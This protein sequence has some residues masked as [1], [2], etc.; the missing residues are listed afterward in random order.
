M[1]SHIDV[2]A[3]VLARIR[4][5]AAACYPHEAIGLLGAAHGQVCAAVP[6]ANAAAMPQRG[7]RVRGDAMTAA[8]AELAARELDWIGVYHSHPDGSA[9]LSRNDVHRVTRSSVEMV[10]SVGRAG[11]GALR[12]FYVTPVEQPR[13]LIVNA[14]GGGPWTSR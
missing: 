5:H 4:D 2:A 13:E 14:G 8:L 7:S 1:Q 6:L 12:A 3:E 9:Q 10:I 11:P